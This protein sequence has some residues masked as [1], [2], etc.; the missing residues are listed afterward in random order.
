VRG[1]V[2]L[3]GGSVQAF[4]KGLGKGSEFVVRLP[5]PGR[6]NRKKELPKI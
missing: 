6:D 2:E 5:I 4:S 3:H 1:L